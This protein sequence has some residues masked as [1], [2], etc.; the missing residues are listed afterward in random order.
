M[1]FNNCAYCWVNDSY[2]I[3][4]SRDAILTWLTFDNEVENNY[5]STS[6]G[7]GPEH[8][9]VELWYTDGLLVQ[10]NI[11]YNLMTT[12]I[13]GGNNGG[14]VFAYNFIMPPHNDSGSTGQTGVS[15]IEPHETYNHDFLIEG[16]KGVVYA[17]DH[18]WGSSGYN[19]LFRNTLTG[20]RPGQTIWWDDLPVILN[21]FS[22][23][24]TVVGN[25]LGTHGVQEVYQI[26]NSTAA[27]APDRPFY[28]YALGFYDL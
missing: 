7:A 19:I 15:S 5:F 8:Y 12:L 26:P 22:R 14:V 24:Y 17:D 23:Y 20:Y 1:E 28:I 10:N 2:F 3:N 11:F 9:T 25:I 18:I 27:A 6:L 21:N 13:P 4:V 16:N